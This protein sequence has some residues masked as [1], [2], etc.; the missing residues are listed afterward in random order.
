MPKATPIKHPIEQIGGSVKKTAWSSVI[1][2]VITMIFG[3]LLVAWPNA[4]IS[5]VANIL[6]IIFIVSGTYKIINYFIVKGQDDYFN[7]DLLAGVL[8]LLIGIA[9]ITVGEDI[10]IV[11][12]IIV[13]I[14]MVYESLVRINTSI[15][16]HAAGINA[17]SYI[18]C[19]A[20]VMMAL[21]LFVTFNNGAIVQL[22]GWMLIVTGIIGIVGDV[23]F[24]H[25][26]NEFIDK[27]SKATK[28]E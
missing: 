27:I 18:L 15:K 5:V 9:A 23:I 3:I 7:N 14:W 17:W 4:T 26:V 28:A 11:F 22:M 6:G 20:L 21:G 19:I 8:A 2:S 10:A 12:R 24:I 13:G 1:E 25:R 16:L